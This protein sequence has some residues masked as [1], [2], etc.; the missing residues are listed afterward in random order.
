MSEKNIVP[1]GNPGTQGSDGQ[2]QAGSLITGILAVIVALLI[3]ALVFF[4]VF[5]VLLRNDVFTLGTR[6]R[7]VLHDQP[8]LGWLLPEAP[9]EYDPDA[10][11]NLPYVE[12]MKRYEA[13][14]QQMPEVEEELTRTQ[15]EL[16]VAESRIEALSALSEAD[17]SD[18]EQREL[19]WEAIAQ[20]KDELDAR[21]VE[22]AA[23][24]AAGDVTAFR[25]Y[26]EQLA[27]DEAAVIYS[28]IMT[29]NMAN[30]VA[31]QAARPF[32][33]MDRKK[34][35]EVMRELWTKDRPLLLTIMDA[36]K[37]QTLAEILAN[38][39]PGLAADITRYLAD[40]RKAKVEEP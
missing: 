12:L 10:A 9:A 30:A 28:E 33:L 5:A 19:E 7:P 8:A 34:A 4:G 39:E 24:V 22:V 16:S 29:A 26:Y 27:P 35:A 36:N 17:V 23:A 37:P 31:T 15:L 1:N 6:L 25:E 32:E 11:E 20:A 18:L 3:V 40:Y 21:A 13:Y 38:M 2:Q 14:R